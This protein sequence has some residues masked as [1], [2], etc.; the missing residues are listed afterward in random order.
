MYI[1]AQSRAGLAGQGH[2]GPR[3]RVSR[4]TVPVLAAA[5]LIGLAKGAVAYSRRSAALKPHVAGTN[6]ITVH[7]VLPPPP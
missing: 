7:L 1:T 4:L 3:M 6:A 2:H 5:F